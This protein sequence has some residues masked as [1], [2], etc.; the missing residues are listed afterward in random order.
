MGKEVRWLEPPENFEKAVWTFGHMMMDFH[1]RW[2]NWF[3]NAGM[4]IQRNVLLLKFLHDHKIIHGDLNAKNIM[5]NEKFQPIITG[6]D[7]T[8]LMMDGK[9]TIQ[10]KST[11]K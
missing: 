11:K 8:N 2:I 10:S 3:Q 5:L 1:Q 6:F 4:K 9:K 7:E